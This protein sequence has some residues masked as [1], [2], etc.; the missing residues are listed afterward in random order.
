MTTLYL[1]SL[2]PFPSSGTL[3][4]VHN[5]LWTRIPTHLCNRIWLLLS[6]VKCFSFMKCTRLCWHH[7]FKLSGN[8][9]LRNQ[10]GS[11]GMCC[12]MLVTIKL[13]WFWYTG[14]LGSSMHLLYFLMWYPC[15]YK[16][17]CKT[18]FVIAFK[19]VIGLCCL[20]FAMNTTQVG[21]ESLFPEQL[22]A[23]NRA[24]VV[25]SI[26]VYYF[27]IEWAHIIIYITVRAWIQG[28]HCPKAENRSEKS[29]QSCALLLR[30][31]S[32]R[33]AGSLC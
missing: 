12:W 31:Q 32:G 19:I 27:Y 3:W 33:P 8:D 7:C 1:S 16:N 17:E 23:T 20:T 29:E 18:R 14:K 28:I 9:R 15:F 13:C 30:L 5:H 26:L 22:S 4:T 10:V 11:V 24:F 25:R 6:L 2:H 21:F